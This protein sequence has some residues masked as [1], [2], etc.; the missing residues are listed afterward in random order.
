MPPENVT[1]RRTAADQQKTAWERVLETERLGDL[2][3]LSKAEQAE[4]RPV[5]VQGIKIMATRL[6][7]S[8][9]STACL[10][11]TP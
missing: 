9:V 2:T 6:S 3:H 1:E 11:P 7:A 5:L 8:R 4:L 10:L